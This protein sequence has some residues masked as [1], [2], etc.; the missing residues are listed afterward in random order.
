MSVLTPLL[1]GAEV[2]QYL[3]QRPPMIL[4]DTLWSIDDTRIVSGLR[5]H[6]ELIFAEDGLLHEPG[7]LEHVAQ[8]AALGA[9]YGS[10]QSGAQVRIGFIGSY[11]DVRILRLPGTGEVLR[12]TLVITHVFGNCT[13]YTAEVESAGAPVAY[14]EIKLFIQDGDSSPVV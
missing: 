11:K 3:P 10:R 8:T 9:G 5:V 4:V 12:T 6:P 13:A 14:M 7:I 1:T 2:E